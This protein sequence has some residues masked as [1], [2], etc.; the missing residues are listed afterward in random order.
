MLTVFAPPL[1]QMT[2][3]QTLSTYLNQHFKHFFWKTKPFFFFFGCFKLVKCDPITW[4]HLSEREWKQHPLVVGSLSTRQK[5][6]L[7]LCSCLTFQSVCLNIKLYTNEAVRYYLREAYLSIQETVKDGDHETLKTREDANMSHTH[8]HTHQQ[9]CKNPWDFS[10][11]V[12]VTKTR[13][14]KCRSDVFCSPGRIR[15]PVQTPDAPSCS[16]SRGRRRRPCSGS[17]TEGS[18][19]AWIEPASW[20]HTQG[21]GN[22]CDRG[23]WSQISQYFLFYIKFTIGI[24]VYNQTAAH[25]R[26]CLDTCPG[27]H[28]HR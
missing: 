15:A 8:T 25:F 22:D 21:S 9:P 2:F 10:S 4:G 18:A 6:D 12:C 7:N 17:R 28:T 19:A 16:R 11:D 23:Q 14:I 26:S 27:N 5:L 24:K 3:I 20:K 1:L 13:L